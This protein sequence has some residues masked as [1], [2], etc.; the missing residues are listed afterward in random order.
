MQQKRQIIISGSVENTYPSGH[1]GGGGG[2]EVAGAVD[3]VDDLSGAADGGDEVG[4]EVVGVEV[5]V[6]GAG[7]AAGEI[8]VD[9]TW[10]ASGG[11]EGGPGEVGGVDM[12]LGAGTGE[13]GKYFYSESSNL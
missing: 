6:L 7:T 8:G 4:P 10:A 2:S 5:M 3:S 13:V 9:I 12:V 11:E 1:G